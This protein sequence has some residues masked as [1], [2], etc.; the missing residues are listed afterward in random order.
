[1][2]RRVR[3]EFLARSV[4]SL[5]TIELAKLLLQLLVGLATYRGSDIYQLAETSP[6]PRLAA[7]NFRSA[8]GACGNSREPGWLERH[9]LQ[10]I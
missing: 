3:P 1:M 2:I 6:L 10:P 5:E 4:I 9:E 7:I 8:L